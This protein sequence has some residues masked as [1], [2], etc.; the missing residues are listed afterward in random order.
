MAN[1]QVPQLSDLTDLMP[2]HAPSIPQDVTSRHAVGGIVDSDIVENDKAQFGT[3]GIIER[4]FRHV[5]T[6]MGNP[7]TLST[8]DAYNGNEAIRW[9]CVI[10]LSKRSRGSTP[11]GGKGQESNQDYNLRIEG[12]CEQYRYHL[13]ELGIKDS[14]KCLTCWDIVSFST[15]EHCAEAHNNNHNGE[16]NPRQH[17]HIRSR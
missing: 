13:N 2:G 4:Q 11:Q 7:T 15:S 6:L 17:W 3:N 16:N 8:D 9:L 5:K 14:K 10:E 12:Y 1:L